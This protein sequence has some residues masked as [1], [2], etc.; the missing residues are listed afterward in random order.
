L[1]VLTTFLSRNNS[2]HN[3]KTTSEAELM[4]HLVRKW[5][6]PVE[7]VVTVVSIIAIVVVVYSVVVDVVVAVVAVV[8]VLLS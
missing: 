8:I 4:A 3:N 6:E 2:G 1:C 5:V 7:I